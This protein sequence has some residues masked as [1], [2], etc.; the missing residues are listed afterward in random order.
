MEKHIKEKILEIFIEGILNSTRYD[1]MIDKVLRK[2]KLTPIELYNYLNQNESY[3]D[4][5]K[6]LDRD[7]KSLSN[8]IESLKTLRDESKEKYNQKNN[9]PEN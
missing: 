8:T 3:K 6:K 7:I 1:K 4:L 9:K 5:Y 2:T